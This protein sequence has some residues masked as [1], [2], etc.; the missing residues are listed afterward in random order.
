MLPKC[1][2]D[3]IRIGRNCPALRDDADERILPAG[4]LAI[5][6][7][8][9]ELTGLTH[10]AHLGRVN[11]RGRYT[12]FF[13]LAAVCSFEIEAAS[14]LPSELRHDLGADLVAAR[15]DPGA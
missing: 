15:A 14:S 7:E 6:P 3:K 5:A 4:G 9:M 2:G 10:R 13:K 8:G 11:A 12:G 1:T